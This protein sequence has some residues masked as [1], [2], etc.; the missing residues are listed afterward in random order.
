MAKGLV[1]SLILVFFVIGIGIGF[2]ITPEY[3]MLN[4]QMKQSHDLGPA[5]QWVD[6]RYLDN[7]VAHHLSA[8]Y[9]LEQAQVQSQ[10][11]E[12]QELSSA[13]IAADKAGIEQL[14]AYK[15]EWYN[16]TRSVSSYNKVNLGTDDGKFDLRLLNALIAH[17]EEAIDSAQQIST[18]STRNEVL[19]LADEITQTL[20]TNKTQLETWRK[21]WYGF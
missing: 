1:S 4:K 12:I 14:Y 20:S 16:N 3:A 17:H 8:I 19:N 11:P 21:E 13:V 6:Q 9:M 5:D 2:Y 15:K 7:M 18:K 10:R